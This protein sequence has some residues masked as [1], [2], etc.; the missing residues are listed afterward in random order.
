MNG[1]CFPRAARARWATAVKHPRTK[2]DVKLQDMQDER[3]GRG[4]G[5]THWVN[6][7]V[8]GCCESPSTMIPA[9]TGA[10]AG[11]CPRIGCGARVCQVSAGVPG[12]M[13]DLLLAR[14]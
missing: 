13:E 11:R 1:Q 4:R 5:E 10:D 14:V 7:H 6:F 9:C 2:Q 3:Q 8:G 12:K